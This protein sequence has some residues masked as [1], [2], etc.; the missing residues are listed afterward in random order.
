MRRKEHI[1]KIEQII[2]DLW[3]NGKWSNMVVIKSNIKKTQ[4]TE[5]KIYSRK[6][7]Q[8]YEKH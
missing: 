5:Q 7:H 4:R 1:E 2:N 6:Y 8:I 3:N